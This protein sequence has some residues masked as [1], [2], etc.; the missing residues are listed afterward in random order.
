MDIGHVA[1]E[2]SCAA[3]GDI[4]SFYCAYERFVGL[5]MSSDSELEL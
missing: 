4:A 2:F 3:E 1:V 5:E